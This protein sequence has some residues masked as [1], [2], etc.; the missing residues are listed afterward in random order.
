MRA[1]LVMTFAVLFM[2]CGAHA[3]RAQ[4]QNAVP[5]P[6]DAELIRVQSRAMSIYDTV[7]AA[8]FAT[9]Q[10]RLQ[11]GADPGAWF[12]TVPLED[13]WYSLFGELDRAG[14]F[15]PAQAFKAP[16]EDAEQVEP[17]SL[18]ALPRDFSPEARAVQ[19]SMTASVEVFQRATISPVVVL[20]DDGDITVYVLQGS[21][22]VTRFALGGDMRFRYGPDG[23]T[24]REAVKLH[25]NVFDIDTRPDQKTGELHAGSVHEH[26]LFG[27]PLETELAMVMLYP[28]LGVVAVGH[29]SHPVVYVL[30]PNGTIRVLTQAPAQRRVLQPDGTFAPIDSDT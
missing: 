29:P 8:S 15:I 14:T 18:D 27:G 10:M 4:M 7:R 5:L 16:L 26:L 30:A 6:D 28:E 3:G 21:V 20:E 24:L 9:E 22:D 23:L 19:A 1:A 2:G 12:L 13:G 11:G 17:L 25:S